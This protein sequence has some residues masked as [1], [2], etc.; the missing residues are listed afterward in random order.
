MTGVKNEDLS[1]KP[2]IS[3]LLPRFLE[4]IGSATIVSYNVEF[5]FKFINAELK[6]ANM[7]PLKNEIIDTYALA[8]EKC[9]VKNYDIRSVAEVLEI[10]EIKTLSYVEK[11]FRVYEKLKNMPSVEKRT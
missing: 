2:L 9:E 6:K 11:I 3:G 10:V 5:N 7:P 1:N 8:K 4:F